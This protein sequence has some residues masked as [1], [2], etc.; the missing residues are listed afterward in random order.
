MPI[1]FLFCEF[2]GNNSCSLGG[3]FIYASGPGYFVM[4]Y[5][6]FGHECC[7]WC[8]CLLSLFLVCTSCYPLDRGCTGVQSA[9]SSRKMEAMGRANSQCL[10][11][12]PLTVART[13]GAVELA[14]PGCSA[15]G[16]GSDHQAPEALVMA[17]A[18]CVHSQGSESNN[19]WCSVAVPFS[20]MTPEVTGATGGTCSWTL[21]GG[22]PCPPWSLR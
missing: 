4:V 22:E 1:F 14:A 15:L 20:A 5:Y 6:F 16:S 3:L 2:R 13:L 10:V 21:S 8:G 17:A 7:F 18:G 9:L 12:R 11:P 19:R